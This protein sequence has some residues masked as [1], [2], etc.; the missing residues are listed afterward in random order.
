MD[1]KNK[2]SRDMAFSVLLLVILVATVF[3]LLPRSNQTKEYQFS[4]IVDFCPSMA[5][6]FN[7]LFGPKISEIMVKKGSGFPP[8][9]AAR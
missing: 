2:R 6:K 1:P 7:G 3:M 5:E 9:L 8:L 4:D